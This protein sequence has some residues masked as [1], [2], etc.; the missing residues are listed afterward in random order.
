MSRKPNRGCPRLPSTVRASQVPRKRVARA[1]CPYASSPAPNGRHREGGKAT[2]VRSPS[3]LEPEAGAGL[4]LRQLPVQTSCMHQLTTASCSSEQG[5]PKAVWAAYCISRPVGRHV[6][7]SYSRCIVF[8]RPAGAIHRSGD[9]S[10]VGV[11]PQSSTS[12]SVPEPGASGTISIPLP[13]GCNWS[14]QGRS[15]ISER[16]FRSDSCCRP[17][18]SPTHTLAFWDSPWVEAIRTQAP[19]ACLWS[20]H[21]GGCS[22]TFRRV[23][24]LPAALR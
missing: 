1:I 5:T 15:A 3:D 9:C 18:P 12:P 24:K 10:R 4:L 23:S 13:A 7:L 21:N 6:L 22:R 17:G 14:A 11:L 16:F 19:L 20:S 2:P 8:V